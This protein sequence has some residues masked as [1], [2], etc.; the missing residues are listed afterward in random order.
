MKGLDKSAIAAIKS[1]LNL[2]DV[3]RR[4]VELR[5]VG[6]RWMG[7]CPFHNET[8]GSF[9][10]NE[11]EGFFYCFGCQ[12]S[13]DVFDFYSRING[14]EFRET[15]EQLAA[16][17][18]VRLEEYGGGRGAEAGPD[19]ELKNQLLGACVLAMDLYRRNLAGT[20]GA[21]CR[22]YLGRRGLSEAVIAAFGLGYS[23][24][25]WNDL[26]ICL[27]ARRISADK[28]VQAGLL[29]RNDKG[30]IYDRFRGRLMFPILN[31]SNQVI[32]F[33][34]R[35]LTANEDPKYLN[36]SDSVIYKK[37]DHLFGLCHAR[38]HITQR[39]Q[40]LLT[41]GYVDV[42]TLH[43]FG[44]QNSCGV[45]GTALTP[46]QI[47]RLA[48]FCGQV[49]LLFDGD[50]AGRKAA[51]RSA[52]M[53]L[54]AGLNCRVALLPEGEDVDSLLQKHGNSA[55]DA[56]L[57]RAP[58]GLDFAM[59]TLRDSFS[60]KELIDWA[61]RFAGQLQ[62]PDLIAYYLPRLASG[63]GLAEIELR[64]ALAPDTTASTH[65]E[66][67]SNP[68]YAGYGQ[69]RGAWR[70]PPGP[71]PGPVNARMRREREL[72]SFV[73]RFPRHLERL[74]QL[75]ALDQLSAEKSLVLWGKLREAGET[76][77]LPQLDEAEKRFYTQSRM[78]VAE[79]SD[80]DRLEMENQAL[81]AMEVFLRQQ[82]HEERKASS[83]RAMPAD[84]TNFE[85]L[86][87]FQQTLGR[88]NG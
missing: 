45:L 5:R 34:A 41:E 77:P 38:S 63:L 54:C 50:A 33:G 1:R 85:A 86:R 68:R 31:L 44:Y 66:A 24:P 12:A 29:S 13:G 62:R 69:R 25:S 32:A 43:Q 19:K 15:L 70:Q 17:T 53:I 6:T 88:K 58:D 57:T 2:V 26:E 60:P 8:K 56:I 48:G 78:V 3:V 4:Y 40:V 84:D 21:A 73:I 20:N 71:K 79:L 46:N 30:N 82:L 23:L 7:P 18:G 76:D 16:E 64:S 22:E 28:G 81:A 72:L 27:K 9:S 10:V 52:E 59:R 51:L 61:R 83:R 55:L 36:S 14:L 74:E 42:I 65:Q 67:P 47:K 49:D 87:A 35:A 75:G 11:A 39:K 80:A 37:G